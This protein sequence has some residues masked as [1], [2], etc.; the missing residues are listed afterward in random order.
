M[1]RR[2]F[3]L[4]EVMFATLIGAMLVLLIVGVLFVL[5]R[6]DRVLDARAEQGSDLYR[7][8]LVM[9]RVSMNFLMS[10]KPPPRATPST[11]AAADASKTPAPTNKPGRGVVRQDATSAAPLTPRLLLDVDPRLDGIK[12]RK[13]SEPDRDYAIQ[14][15]EVVVTD[16]P[17]PTDDASERFFASAGAARTRRQ[18]TH[19][20]GKS[21]AGARASGD[22]SVQAAVF[23]EEAQGMVRAVRGA[24]EFWP[25]TRKTAQRRLED[26]DALRGGPV[27]REALWE[28][29]WV[30]LAPRGD[31]EDEDLGAVTPGAIGEPYLVASN[32]RFARWTCFDDRE[33]KLRLAAAR[34]AELPAYIELELETATGMNV[35]WMFETDGAVG[36]EVPPKPSTDTAVPDVSGA[37][38]S[39][40]GG[41]AGKD[42][43][44][45]E[46]GS[47]AKGTSAPAPATKAGG[48]GG[49]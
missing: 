10:S 45:S 14:R 1:N 31:T 35:H 26:L 46:S 25:Q 16:S 8:R 34:R 38:G 5:E 41:G 49:S 28:L 13:T 30:P 43:G 39:S 48:K 40:K 6:S 20:G 9:Q 36:P 15:F 2:A 17:V 32:I 11:D 7:A 37:D 29:W 23:A 3:T 19:A 33:K 18:A 24:L 4:L 42:K 44:S 21:S 47:K 22:A 12:M 27:Q